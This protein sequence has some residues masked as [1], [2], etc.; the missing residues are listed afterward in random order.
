MKNLALALIASTVALSGT[1]ATIDSGF[2]LGGAVG[3]GSIKGQYSIPGATPGNAISG[4]QS[5]GDSSF[6]GGIHAGYG[7]VKNCFYLGCEIGATYDNSKIKNTLNG[8]VNGAA[9]VGQYQLKRD[10]YLNVALR[11]GYLIA[12]TT[13][14]Y[15]RLGVNASKWT[16][17]DTNSLTGPFSPGSPSSGSKNSISFAP[18]I[19]V[20]AALNKHLYVRL[21][22]T[23]E[24]AP[25][26]IATNVFIAGQATRVSNIRS[27]ATKV[28]LF[29]RF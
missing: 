1:K 29:Y 11:G 2:F 3:Y 19:G 6:N 27:Q 10:W 5:V 13:M 25:S 8:F 7:E 12:P 20:E 17:S 24:F 26:L 4:S 16:F 9:L 15:L 22:Y 28:G 21:E 14:A 18:G 23:Y